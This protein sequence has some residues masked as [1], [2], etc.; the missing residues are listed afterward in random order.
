MGLLL[1]IGL[2]VGVSVAA[3]IAGVLATSTRVQVAERLDHLAQRRPVVGAAVARE[4]QASFFE[5]VIAPIFAR[6]GGRAGIGSVERIRQKLDMAGYPGGLTTE[7]FLAIRGFLILVGTGIAAVVFLATQMDTLTKFFVSLAAIASTN[8]LPEYALTVYI[9]QRQ[10]Q[11]RKSL[12][13]II[14][15]L[16]VST[17]AGVGLDTALQEVIRRRHGPLVYEFQRLLQEV[18]LGKPRAEAWNDM[19]ERT[20]VE[21]VRVLVQSLLQ[22][23]QLGISV[24]KT[25]RTQAATLRSRRSAKIKIMAATLAVKMLFPLIFFIFPALLVVVLGPAVISIS[26]AFGGHG[27]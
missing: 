1:A 20:G 27:W 25:L 9:R 23:E 21:E 22:A 5:R 6:L 11:I 3:L 13:D 7:A 4:L 26:Q 14:D 18:R 10:T 17:E 15:L 2:L 8:F 19:A 24:A 12:P 16:V